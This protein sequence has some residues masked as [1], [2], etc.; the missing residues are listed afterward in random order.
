MEK[1]KIKIL[2]KKIGI[3]K[4]L[5]SLIEIV[6][7]SFDSHTVPMWKYRVIDDLEN[8]YE[9]FMINTNSG[10]YQDA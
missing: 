5:Q 2:L 3:K 1:D 9:Q 10:D 4:T 8:A 6:D 7:E